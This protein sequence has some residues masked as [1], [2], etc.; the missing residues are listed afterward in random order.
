LSIDSST[1]IGTSPNSSSL[2]PMLVGVGLGCSVKTV[3][4]SGSDGRA[5]LRLIMFN[6]DLQVAPA[7]AR[8]SHRWATR[9]SLL[10][11]YDVATT[12]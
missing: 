6:A 4:L 11:H 9:I 7:V 2:P 8:D 1:G 12:G 5:S 3:T 10:S